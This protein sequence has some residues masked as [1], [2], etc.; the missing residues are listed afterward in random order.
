MT[1]CSSARMTLLH[2]TSLLH[3]RRRSDTVYHHM[4]SIPSRLDWTRRSGCTIVGYAADIHPASAEVD[5]PSS[6]LH[7]QAQ[8]SLVMPTVSIGSIKIIHP[9]TILF[10]HRC[11][12]VSSIPEGMLT[13]PVSN[14]NQLP[15]NNSGKERAAM[16]GKSGNLHAPPDADCVRK[17]E[18]GSALPPPSPLAPPLATLTLYLVVTRLPT[19][20]L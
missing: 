1:I 20:P 9:S 18:N 8:R 10:R 2:S 3:H 14:R 7:F 19:K 17:E 12:I 15:Y 5:P 11:Y 6:S 16:E 4:S 13:P